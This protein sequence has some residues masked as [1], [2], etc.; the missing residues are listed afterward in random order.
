MTSLEEQGKLTDG[1]QEQIQAAIT[2]TELEDLYLPYRPK[3]RTRAMIAKE[4]GL[5]P[6]AQVIWEQGAQLDV[7]TE[8][9]KFLNAE[10]G[11]DS[12]DEALAGSAPQLGI[13]PH[14]VDSQ[15]RGKGRISVHLAVVGP[16]HFQRRVIAAVHRPDDNARF[17]AALLK[18]CL[19]FGH[20][21]RADSGTRSLKTGWLRPG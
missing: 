13:V 19:H 12:V 5:E 4:R 8:A 21:I 17:F 16:A 10:Q 6:L 11:V 14:R 1:L 18:V 7:T 15:S 2:M 3:R 20:F 9:E